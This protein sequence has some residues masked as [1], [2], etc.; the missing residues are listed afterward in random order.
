MYMLLCGNMPFEG[1]SLE[2]IKNSIKKGKINFNNKD[3]KSKSKE[4]RDLLKKLLEPDP[5]KRINAIHALEHK[6]FKKASSISFKKEV[7]QKY[8]QNMIKINN[9]LQIHE[10]I[11]NLS[12]L[13]QF[14]KTEKLKLNQV[15]NLNE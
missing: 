3:L 11:M 15:F 5:K 7:A 9:A 14:I 8:N 2:Q 12:V 13:Q 4:A 6:W 10:T 1:K